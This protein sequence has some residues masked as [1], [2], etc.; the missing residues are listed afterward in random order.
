MVLCL[1]MQ[2]WQMWKCRLT[3]EADQDEADLDE[4]AL[5]DEVEAAAPALQ[6]RQ[7]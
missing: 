6:L 2:R 7:D 1:S 5:K 4:M 3:V